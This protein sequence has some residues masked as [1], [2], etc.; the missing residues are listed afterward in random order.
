MGFSSARA[1]AMP[2]GVALERLV[3]VAPNAALSLLLASGGDERTR[4]DAGTGRTKYG[5]PSVPAEGEIWFS[6]ATASAIDPR[7]Y[8]A[9]RRAFEALLGEGGTQP[10]D[11]RLWFDDLRARL[12]A[13]FGVEGTEVVLSASGTEAELIALTLARGVLARPLTNLVI[14][15]TETGSGVMQAAAGTHFLDTSSLAGSVV[16]D[17]ALQGF[18]AADIRVEGIAIRD[19]QGAPRA[20]ADIDHEAAARVAYALASGRDVLLHVMDTSK[21]G[22]NGVTREV[23]RRLAGAAKGR[24]LVAVDACQL[25]ASPARLRADLEAG[26]MVMITGSKFAGG[27]PFAGALLVPQVLMRSLQG[28]G[29]TPEGLDAY[30]ASLDWPS[31]LRKTFGADL[32]VVANLGLG[33]RWEAALALLEPYFAVLADLRLHILDWFAAAVESRIAA[34]PHLRLAQGL[35]QD[36]P[37]I[38]PVISRGRSATPEGAALLYKGLS[39]PMAPSGAPA[40]LA[41]ACHVGQP[42]PIGDETALRI[43]ASM[44]LVLDIARRIAEGET[45]EDA[46]APATAYLDLLF[47][48]W[49]WLVARDMQGSAPKA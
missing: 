36:V 30:S 19:V 11:P 41:R 25:R 38:F 13:Q 39:A 48:K 20:P 31:A 43:C 17:Q 29:T 44:P 23:A 12:V 49:D 3:K 34:R 24:V 6:S 40:A 7:G 45:I 5:T 21:T 37:T 35:P 27:P 15:P 22:L 14:A 47:C 33:L 42:V 2:S 18:A 46:F 32:G 10:L 4:L 28:R 26:F 8:A 16:R 9:A 1:T